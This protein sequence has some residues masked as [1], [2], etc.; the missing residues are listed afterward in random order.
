MSFKI[1]KIKSLRKFLPVL[2]FRQAGLIAGM[3]LAILFSPQIPA[4]LRLFCPI[5]SFRRAGGKDYA[6]PSRTP[7]PQSVSLSHYQSL[8]S[9]LEQAGFQFED[10]QELFQDPRIE[11]YDDIAVSL[12]KPP[13]MDNYSSIY[14]HTDNETYEIDEFIDR[15]GEQLKEAEQRY[16]VDLEAIVAVL[17]VETKIGKIVGKYSVFNILSSLA[18]ADSPESLAKIENHVNEHYHYLN[19]DK[20]RGLIN[21]YQERAIRKSFRARA[22]FTSLLQLHFDSHIDILELPGSY[23]GAFGY[24]QF[25]PSNVTRYGIDGDKDGKIDLYNFTDAIMSVG[26]FLSK[27]G[28]T[29]DTDRQQRALLRYNNS[30]AYVA[31]VLETANSIRKDMDVIDQTDLLLYSS[32]E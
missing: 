12:Y 28:W 6:I 22:E 19:Y 26:N 13:T 31:Y 9:H 5:S 3:T 2:P 21:I 16:G 23:A 27:K 30:R 17:F 25:M 1:Y 32:E 20:R 18:V 8:F 29:K 14:F 4:R 15:Y 11:Y 10:I 24:P 7:F